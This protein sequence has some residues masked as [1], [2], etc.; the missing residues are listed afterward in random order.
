MN[1]SESLEGHE[2]QH[3]V[4]GH[5]AGGALAW[6]AS[7]LGL[8]ADGDRKAAQRRGDENGNRSCAQS[9]VSPG[10]G[11]K[12]QRERDGG[13]VPQIARVWVFV[14]IAAGEL[15]CKTV[16]KIEHELGIDF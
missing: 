8:A 3:H 4:G 11:R 1:E 6:A 12:Q 5:S 9:Y 14:T 7:C 15:F 2:Q 16:S 10:A 13:G